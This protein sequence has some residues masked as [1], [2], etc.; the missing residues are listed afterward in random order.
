LERSALFAMAQAWF[1][2]LSQQPLVLGDGIPI[3]SFLIGYTRSHP[4]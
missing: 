4:L 1:N 3:P 2:R